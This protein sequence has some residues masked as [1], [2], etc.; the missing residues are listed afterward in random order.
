MGARLM[1]PRCR[2]C[3]DGV[4]VVFTGKGRVETTC[5]CARGLERKE[6]ALKQALLK[7]YFGT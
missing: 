4:V 3:R 1:A 5:H 2:D 7:A 6:E